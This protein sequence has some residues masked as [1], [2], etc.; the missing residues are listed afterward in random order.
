MEWKKSQHL[1]Q[2]NYSLPGD[3]LD[4]EYFEALNILFRI[5]NSLRIFVYI[6]LK[7][8][9]KEKWNEL[10]ITSDDAESSTIKS[11][12]KKRLAQ[13]KNY[14]Y[15]GYVLNSPLLHLTSGELIR[16]ITSDSYWKYFKGYFLGSRE[17]IKN[18]LDEIG[19]VRNSLAH[20]RPIKEGDLD[21]V[22]QNSI[23]TLS[24]IE[25]TVIDIINCPDTVPTNTEDLWYNELITLGTENVNVS[26]KQSINEKWITLELEFKPPKLSLKNS[27][28]GGQD[29]KTANLKTDKVLT[30]FPKLA[31][32]L[33][34]ATE[35]LPFVFT[36]NPESA[37][38]KMQIRMTFSKEC[39]A[40]EYASI[41]SELQK[42]LI[43]IS[44][45]LDLIKEDN[46]ARGKLIEV[47]NCHLEKSGESEYFTA[48]QEVF[49]TNLDEDSPVEFWG[50]I[51][52]AGTNYLTN[53][54]KYPWMP[55]KI[56]H[57]KAFPF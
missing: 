12:A 49:R 10:A 43:Q 3:W 13:D 50:T 42:I 22:K 36:K 24:E 28:F 45:E 26:F 29:L 20:F 32:H 41:K 34:C 14:A 6:V 46:L 52:R 47:V 8:Q 54:D 7:D 17:I 51:N 31:K 2:N 30:N 25:K 4:I 55:V 48:K 5:E 18:K 57:D 15:L 1:K 53:T 33:I 27:V 40:K 37:F 44:Q 16:I 35:T 39:I 9:Y 38:I 23:H 21:L 11:I 19:N 56:S